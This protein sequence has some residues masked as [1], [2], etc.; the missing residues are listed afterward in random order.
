MSNEPKRTQT[1][2]MYE[3]ALKEGEAVEVDENKENDV[4]QRPPK[5]PPQAP[6]VVADDVKKHVQTI[7]AF[8]IVKSVSLE[9]GKMLKF[10]YP[11]TVVATLSDALLTL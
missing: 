10:S 2:N 8:T 7:N 1:V 9:D 11:Y 6:P 4:T 3:L 5:P